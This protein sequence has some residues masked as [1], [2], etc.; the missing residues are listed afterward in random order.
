MSPLGLLQAERFPATPLSAGAIGPA[1]CERAVELLDKLRR[2]EIVPY[3]LESSL[4][5]L[6]QAVATRMETDDFKNTSGGPFVLTRMRAF[7]AASLAASSAGAVFQNVSVK[8]IDN[9]RNEP[10]AKAPVLLPVYLAVDDNALVLDRPH[11]LAPDGS[12]GVMVREGDTAG[13][14][15]LFWAFL[16]EVLYG[17]LLSA[18]EVQE[19]I[20]LGLYPGFLGREVAWAQVEAM[21]WLFGDGPRCATLA[22]EA[23]RWA[24]RER[25]ADL[26]QKLAWAERS[27]YVFGAGVIDITTNAVTSLPIGRFRNESGSPVA[28]FRMNLA[29]L[30]DAAASAAGAVFSNVSLEVYHSG[31][32]R[33]LT[34]SPVLAP[35]LV[36]IRDSEWVF[37]RPLVLGPG[38][39]MEINAIEENVNGTTNVYAAVHGEHVRGLS[40]AELREAVSLGL[41]QPWRRSYT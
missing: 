28:L 9:D 41:Y 34:K 5:N 38:E 10:L 26:R 8:P 4:L 1:L 15:D 2:T 20:A 14:T 18:R 30:T 25:V 33:Q 11:V 24:L 37:E 35:C 17:D 22:G 36:G 40:A 13:T 23:L 27:T 19:L 7:T 31:P 32:N 16:G 29:T 39:A 3:V 6:A 21:R 12:L